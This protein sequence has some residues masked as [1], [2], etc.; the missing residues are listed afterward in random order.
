MQGIDAMKKLIEQI[1]KFGVVGVVCFFIDF[2]L[3][4]V[5]TELFSI[6][7]LISSGISFTVS[8]T[9]NYL[10]SMRYVF[11]S[12]NDSNKA[13]EFIIFVTL[14]IVG[15]GINQLLMWIMVDKAHIY[16]MASKIVTT[17]IVMIYNFITR[18]ILLEK[19]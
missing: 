10:L 1:L 17:A 12:K 9:V 2:G 15:L 8:V 6:N 19:H 13:A 11:A 5:L 3:M 7:Y 4:V 16:Y 14:S 18:K